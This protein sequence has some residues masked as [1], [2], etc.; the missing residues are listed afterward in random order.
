MEYDIRPL[1]LRTLKLLRQFQE[2]CREHG[3]RWYATAGTMLGAV[4]H[5]GFIPW[6][7]DMDIAMPR[8]DYDRL[9]AHAAEWLP[10]PMELVCAELDESYPLPFA[11]LQDASTTI[12]ER[13]HLP[14]LGGIYID[15]FP[16][17]GVPAGGLR[18]RLHFAR[19]EYLKRVLYFVYRDPYK[20]G[21][22]P[23]SWLPLLARKMYSRKSIHAAIRRLQAKY[24]CDQSALVADYDDGLR[25]VMPRTYL[26]QPTSIH[27]EG[28]EINGYERPHEY[29]KLKYGPGYKQLP[30]VGQ[31]RQHHFF[32]LDLD[33]PYRES[34]SKVEALIHSTAQ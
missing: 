22:G 8:P 16:I 34:R 9:I 31:R 32:Y 26:G 14:F 28:V 20:H 1:Q 25:G 18:R 4:R 33:T 7:D 6:D 15:I 29:L 12:L 19:H 21:H 27:F 24:P 3:L 13:P 5:A 30:P 2:V 23:S 11:K 10:R 17:D